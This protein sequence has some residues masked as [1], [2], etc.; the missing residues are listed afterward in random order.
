MHMTSKSVLFLAALLLVAAALTLQSFQNAEAA[1]GGI[2]TATYSSGTLRVTIPFHGLHPGAGQLTVEVLDPEDA[3]LGRAEHRVDVVAAG[4]SWREEIQLAK[5]PSL[6]DLVWHR[7]RY[8]FLYVDQKDA[9]LQNTESISEILRTPVVHVL[10]QQ[11]Y[12]TGGAPPSASSSPIRRMKPSP[13]PGPCTST[14]WRPPIAPACSS[15][16]A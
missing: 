6:D 12:L 4:G 3:V 11:S 2:A 9:A 5:P 10:G 15:P 16:A 8:R 14:S 1:P 13:G 7:V